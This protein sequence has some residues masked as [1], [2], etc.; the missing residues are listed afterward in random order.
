MAEMPFDDR[1]AMLSR[2]RMGRKAPA[3]DRLLRQAAFCDPDAN[4]CDPLRSRPC[5]RS[6]QGDGLSNCTWVDADP[7]TS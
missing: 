5:A 6:R 7:E 1:L 4:V 3:T 2:R